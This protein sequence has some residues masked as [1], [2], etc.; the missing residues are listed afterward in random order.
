[1]LE[2]L[3]ATDNQ[4]LENDKRGFGLF[5]EQR[6]KTRERLALLPHSVDTEGS[7][8]KGNI[9]DR[10]PKPALHMSLRCVLCVP[11]R[12]LGEH[13]SQGEVDLRVPGGH[14]SV[15]ILQPKHDDL[16]IHGC[17]PAICFLVPAATASLH[18][19][20]PLQLLL[21]IGG[22]SPFCLFLDLVRVH[23]SIQD[24]LHELQAVVDCIL[25][26]QNDTGMSSGRVRPMLE[27]IS[28]EE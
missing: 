4:A 26:R 14:Q 3:E 10:L 2:G 6:P 15:G 23:F 25:R 13:A 24:G 1:M 19:Y 22:V 16:R 27:Y 12:P 28:V 5:L 11:V 8:H 9:F 21:D 17:V 18:P 7:Q 20:R